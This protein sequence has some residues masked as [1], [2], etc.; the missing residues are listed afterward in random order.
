MNLKGLYVFC[1]VIT[2][3]NSLS[4]SD[5]I[6][7][8]ELIETNIIR[9]SKTF[10]G[11]IST[12]NN[13]YRIL[14]SVFELF[15]DLLVEL[16][17]PAVSNQLQ[18][19]ED[20][21]TVP[22]DCL[23][24]VGQML[25]EY[26]DIPNDGSLTYLNIGTIS[27]LTVTLDN[28]LYLIL[29]VIYNNGRE[30]IQEVHNTGSPTIVI[31]FYEIKHNNTFQEVKTSIY[32]VNFINFV[33]EYTVHEIE[34]IIVTRNINRYNQWSTQQR[35]RSRI[36]FIQQEAID[37]DIRNEQLQESAILA[38][39][40]DA[41]DTLEYYGISFLREYYIAYF[42]YT[43]YAETQKLD[44]EFYD[45]PL[46]KNVI[47]INRIVQALWRQVELAPRYAQEAKP[48]GLLYPSVVQD[49]F[50][51]FRPFIRGS[52]PSAAVQLNPIS[53]TV[54]CITRGPTS[55]IGALNCVQNPLQTVYTYPQDLRTIDVGD[56]TIN[57]EPNQYIILRLRIIST[58]N[59]NF[60]WTVRQLNI[61]FFC[62]SCSGPN[63]ICLESNNRYNNRAS[64]LNDYS[65]DMNNIEVYDAY[66]VNEGISSAIYDLNPTGQLIINTRLRQ[67]LFVLQTP[68]VAEYTINGVTR[69]VIKFNNIQFNLGTIFL[70][71]RDIC[72]TFV[73]TATLVTPRCDNTYD[74][75]Y[76]FNIPGNSLATGTGVKVCN[77][78][79]FRFGVQRCPWGPS[80]LLPRY[81]FAWMN[82]IDQLQELNMF[83]V[84]SFQYINFRY[85]YN[86]ERI[87]TNAPIASY[88]SAIDDLAQ[89]IID[90][91]NRL[92]ALEDRVERIEDYIIESSKITIWDV[93]N[94]A[95]NLY[96]VAG[97][98]RDSAKLIRTA[99]NQARKSL[100]GSFKQNNV[101]FDIGN[102]IDSLTRVTRN[103]QFN[104]VEAINYGSIYDTIHGFRKTSI[105]N[106]T[107]RNSNLDNIITPRVL[108]DNNFN[109]PSTS[110]DVKDL[111][112]TNNVIS[113]TTQK[114]FMDRLRDP[115]TGTNGDI[116]P[117]G[118][119]ETLASPIEQLGP[120]GKFGYNRDISNPS[121]SNFNTNSKSTYLFHTSV[122]TK[123]FELDINNKW[124]FSTRYSGI[125]EP[126]VLGATTMPHQ[127]KVGYLKIEYDLKA[128]TGNTVSLTRR[129]WNQ[130][131]K[132]DVETYT[133]L[134]IDNLFKAFSSSKTYRERQ[135]ESTDWKWLYI[136]F[137]AEQKYN[138]RKVIQTQPI[139]NPLYLKF[140]DRLF[141]INFR[142]GRLSGFKYNL[143][144]QNC[145]TFAKTQSQLLTRGITNVQ[146][147]DQGLLGFLENYKQIARREFSLSSGMTETSW[148]STSFVVRALE[149]SKSNIC[150]YAKINNMSSN[151]KIKK[152]RY[153]ILD[154]AYKNDN[155]IRTV[156][157]T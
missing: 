56:I 36:A 153:S 149:Y 47:Y 154:K 120:L 1:A 143:L 144:N 157:C 79:P 133:E 65:F 27:S 49:L 62:S 131:Y 72:A 7:I 58:G 33:L 80:A 41:A 75:N 119:V 123:S 42:Q 53:T 116:M 32:Y 110:L 117:Y 137:A 103:N 121:L 100:R 39:L 43:I 122:R 95:T 138:Q 10:N 92:D 83:N 128:G 129:N 60:Q 17:T 3:I 147:N 67:R 63:L 141:D 94:I 78:L 71:N 44:P 127:I 113:M 77:N 88:N 111:I 152:N 57:L 107:I 104:P 29:T 46:E 114:S 38:K 16:D 74:W 87:L 124:V 151:I 54:Q 99:S 130:V 13:F 55:A 76:L 48:E 45:D 155:T 64:A 102:K 35:S 40:H 69:P 23:G 59:C 140:M 15:N 22:N 90:E 52:I 85:N 150:Y 115:K 68:S 132:N 98:I 51:Q 112:N 50:V 70:S 81:N 106:P 126:S 73:Q 12:I 148:G 97:I 109:L 28:Q 101:A 9:L 134:D 61:N 96:D 6:Q 136:S 84:T 25:I 8:R 142:D 19:F 21:D 93:L 139:A 91:G 37:P 82:I 118:V 11:D 18:L 156:I 89:L 146:I 135:N 5:L 66:Y 86:T 108:H 105:S 4:Q 31:D 145:Q 125:G 14:V 24:I 20:E 2:A 34:D 30:T 26:T